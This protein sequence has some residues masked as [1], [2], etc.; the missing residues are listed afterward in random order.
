MD[1]DI[2]DQSEVIDGG[3]CVV[4]WLCPLSCGSSTAVGLA[5]QANL[6]PGASS[7][8]PPSDESDELRKRPKRK[9]A[10]SLSDDEADAEEPVK[11]IDLNLQPDVVVNPTAIVNEEQ[12]RPEAPGVVLSDPNISGKF[13][14][15]TPIV[16]P[17]NSANTPQRPP[18][19]T[20][21]APVTPPS[22]MSLFGRAVNMIKTIASSKVRPSIASYPMKY[23]RRQHSVT[24]GC[25]L[26]TRTTGP[27][28]PIGPIQQSV[29]YCC[30]D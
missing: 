28:Q 19:T 6:L 9:A 11:V 21:E 1:V 24:D 3:I 14:F 26:H 16:A 12:E 29:N 5:S 2:S 17:A 22:A 25:I 27:P 7:F 10:R 13:T 8:Q 23:S 30:L 18:L 20:S 4:L 15:F